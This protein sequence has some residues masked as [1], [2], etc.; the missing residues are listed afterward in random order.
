MF[1]IS[2]TVKG[3]FPNGEFGIVCLSRKLNFKGGVGA[4]RKRVRTDFRHVSREGHF[5]KF[6]AVF[7]GVRA[8]L[9]YLRRNDVVARE[10]FKRQSYG[11][12][13][14]VA[15]H[16]VNRSIVY[17]FANDVD[18]FEF[19]ASVKFV[20]GYFARPRRQIDF[21]NAAAGVVRSRKRFV[22]QHKVCAINVVFRRK[23]DH[24][25]LIRRINR[26]SFYASN[27]RR[28]GKSF[29]SGL[30]AVAAENVYF[31]VLKHVA[32]F[33]LSDFNVYRF[34]HYVFFYLVGQTF[35]FYAALAFYVVFINRSQSRSI[36]SF[37]V[38]AHVIYVE[39]DDVAAAVECRT[40]VVRAVCTPLYILNSV[41][42]S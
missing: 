28:D 31:P 13:R 5:G 17:G 7:K 40:G 11:V 29:Y 34:G 12:A 6:Y 4:T 41:G 18:S 22:F 33:V 24:F 36:R 32:V 25:Q 21:S 23:R 38:A 20:T 10:S 26:S 30:R 3:F 27:G 8:Y 42:D 9:A 15:Y 2:A 1:E 16:T 19:F 39:L 35:E 37:V 14:S